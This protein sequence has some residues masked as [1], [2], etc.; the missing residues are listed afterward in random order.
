MCGGVD[1]DVSR[2]LFK[3]L[4]LKERKI[5]VE[6][7]SVVC[8][9]KHKEY[10]MVNNQLGRGAFGQTVLLKD[11]FIDEL[12]V[13]KKY[14]PSIDEE[15]EKF[16]KR[17]LDE[18]KI[19]YKLNH[20]NIVRIFN[21]YV[22]EKLY[23]GYI[24]MEYIDGCNIADSIQNSSDTPFSI[25][26]NDIFKQ[27]IDAFCYIEKAGIVHRDIRETNILIDSNGI[28]KI[29][30]FGLGKMCEMRNQVGDSL[31]FQVE[32]FGVQSYPNEFYGLTYTSKTDMFYVGELFNR[33]IKGISNSQSITFDYYEIIKKMMEAQPKDRYSSFEE[34]KNA[35]NHGVFSNMIFTVQDKKV[36][37]NFSCA[38]FNSLNDY[39]IKP[40][41]NCS[42][43]IFITRLEDALKRNLLE[44]NI[45]NNSDVISCLVDTQYSYT[46]DKKI[47]VTTVRDFLI[48][49]KNLSDEL[50]K[51]VLSSL[52]SKVSV[53]KTR[54]ED[55]LPF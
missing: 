46:N 27:V 31:A 34:I 16:F 40:Q 38:L 52:V 13:A 48:W 45:S 14:M 1:E 28:V 2:D 11:P 8:F 10:I 35:I 37:Q 25:S 29:I 17:F 3:K 44:N 5:M 39:I 49:F 9:E 23:T 33:L 24:I 7:G 26:I 18:I 42:P 54:F 32:R 22:I 20:Q 51:V 21:Y 15:Q 41:F 53:K 43:T 6:N 12:F 19:L 30:D 4:N 36:Y 47:S 55:D 50:Q